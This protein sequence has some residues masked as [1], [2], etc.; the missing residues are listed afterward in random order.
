M[1]YRDQR[2][3]IE[4]NPERAPS[5]RVRP[6]ESRLSH[7]RSENTGLR[8]DC[9]TSSPCGL[10]AGYRAFA[11]D[12]FAVVVDTLAFAVDISAVA[13]DIAVAAVD[14]PVAAVRT[15]VVDTFYTHQQV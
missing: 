3:Y 14:M 1:W 2:D 13:L 12:I 9:D 5:E 15:F 7:P 8:D 11:V 6:L 4:D 10:V